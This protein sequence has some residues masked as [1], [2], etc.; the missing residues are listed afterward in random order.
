MSISGLIDGGF[1][2]FSFIA[3]DVGVYSIFL[4][5][6]HIDHLIFEDVHLLIEF[7][8]SDYWEQAPFLKANGCF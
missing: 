8:L 7:T 4:C 1:I 3:Q 6:E 5:F 2:R